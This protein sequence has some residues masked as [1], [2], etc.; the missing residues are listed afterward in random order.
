MKCESPW[1]PREDAIISLRLY[2]A[3]EMII[4]RIKEKNEL[5]KINSI[6]LRKDDVDRLMSGEISSHLSLITNTN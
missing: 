4:E 2:S 1:Y 6:N 3:I 5:L